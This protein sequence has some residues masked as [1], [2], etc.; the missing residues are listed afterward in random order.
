MCQPELSKDL[1][2]INARLTRVEEQLKTGSF[3]MAPA[4][5]AARQEEPEDER[6]PMPDDDDAPPVMDAAPASRDDTPAGFW[7]DLTSAV[8][9]DLKP[10]VTGFFVTAPN[11]P[12]RG[13]L[14][15]DMLELRC[16]V[17]FA[18][19]VLD[20]PQILETVSRKASAILGRP[21][22]A[23]VVDLTAKPQKN[24][25]MEELLKFSRDHADVINI[26]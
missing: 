21:I 17:D 14:V 25:R 8:R 20:K 7:A 6:P 10:P 16:A 18:A 19:Q 23:K 12:V 3:V 15:G 4:P 9:T 5:A 2:A 13:V 1:E 11:S 22:Q 26:K 24:P